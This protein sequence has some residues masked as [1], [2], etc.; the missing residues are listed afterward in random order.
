MPYIKQHTLNSKKSNLVLAILLE[1]LAGYFLESTKTG[2]WFFF[3]F[4][5]IHAAASYFFSRALIQYLPQKYSFEKDKLIFFFFCICFFV[6][7]IGVLGLYI[8]WN[9]GLYWPRTSAIDF[10][11]ITEEPPLPFKPLSINESNHYGQAGLPGIV[12]NASN[13]QKRLKAIMATRQLDDRDAIPILRIALKDPVDEVR[14]LAY[15]MLDAKEQKINT[16]IQKIEKELP[17][18]PEASKAGL[19]KELAHYY[20]ELSYLGLAQGDVKILVLNQAHKYLELALKQAPN[21]AGSCFEMGRVL[22]RLNRLKEANITLHK[23]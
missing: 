17:G 12:K 14:L 5:F 15:S 3:R 10:Y 20:W 8:A 19:Y 9:A 6:P 21:D 16:G 18:S 13:A 1:I 4:L 2:D 23:P 22:L 7:F 11:N